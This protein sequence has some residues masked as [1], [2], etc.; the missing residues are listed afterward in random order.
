MYQD[1]CVRAYTCSCVVTSF[2]SGYMKIDLI[3]MRLMDHRVHLYCGFAPISNDQ[4]IRS[5]LVYCAFT[6]AIWLIRSNQRGKSRWCFLERFIAL[7]PIPA[8][9]INLLTLRIPLLFFRSVSFARYPFV[10]HCTSI[11][12]ID[13]HFRNKNCVFRNFHPEI[14]GM[15][16]NWTVFF[17]IN[18]L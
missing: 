17:V 13:R 8:I 12:V 16:L 14:N 18:H 11:F 3:S 1:S 9:F 15:E 4:S 5:T 7:L 2:S 6:T 10:H